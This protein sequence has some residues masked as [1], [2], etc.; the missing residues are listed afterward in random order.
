MQGGDNLGYELVVSS[1]PKIWIKE[2][3]IKPFLELMEQI[4][5]NDLDFHI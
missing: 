3:Y 5:F 4:L 1:E 2:Y